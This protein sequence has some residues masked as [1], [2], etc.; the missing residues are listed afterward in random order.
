MVR[1]RY[2]P[3]MSGR[4]RM[5]MG[6][7]TLDPAKWIEPDGNLASEL[8]EK[9]RLL[10]ERH[11]EVVQARP[12]SRAAQQ[13]TLE[14]LIDHMVRHHPS[15][16]VRDGGAVVL[17]ETGRRYA[18]DDWRRTPVDLAGRLVQEDFLLLAGGEAG[19]TLEAAS[20]CF[21]SRWR[22]AEKMGR[23]L[24][25]IH[26]PV[27]GY[28]DRLARPVDRFFTHLSVRRPVW[29]VNWSVSDDPALFQTER[30][31]RPGAAPVSR[32]DAGERLYLRCERQTLSRLPKTGWALFT[33]KTHIDPLG[34]LASRPDAAT[35]LAR[36]VRDLPPD[37]QAYKNIG[38][39][40]EALLGWLD[41]VAAGA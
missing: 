19:Y 5:G 7:Q 27:P 6:L 13:E 21:P 29:R 3:F 38:H 25:R 16:L 2:L 1:P 12:G 18:L 20:L 28:P 36:S 24:A 8:A 31:A 39:F 23:P 41:G 10:S 33:V 40:R 37:M 30:R 17:P 9:D 4:Y 32:A 34:T 35:A 14:L 15:L 22:L 11:H 26:D